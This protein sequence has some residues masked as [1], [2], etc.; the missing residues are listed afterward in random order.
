MLTLARPFY[1]DRPDLRVGGSIQ[2]RPGV[3][4]YRYPASLQLA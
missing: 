1:T 3:G 2:M 4:R